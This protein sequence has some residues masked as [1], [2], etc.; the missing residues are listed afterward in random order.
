MV[1]KIFNILKSL[2]TFDKKVEKFNDTIDHQQS[3]IELGQVMEEV[4]PL[5]NDFVMGNKTC[6]IIDDSFGQVTVLQDDVQSI[7]DKY[8]ITDINILCMHSNMAAFEVNDLLNKHK[9]SLNIQYVI[10]D[11]TIGGS[12]R[13]GTENI[14]LNGVDV[15]GFL[16]NF[17]DDLKIVIYT[18]NNLNNYIDS[19]R[20]LIE[21]FKIITDK[22][23]CDFT[24][25]KRS[26]SILER[27]SELAKRLFDIKE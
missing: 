23:I 20:K 6:L 21:K 22:D 7:F 18:G 26:L 10:A 19:N 1:K 2:F 8:G 24:I 13:I 12:K 5:P 14:K 3:I 15:I 4:V 17:C 9:D 27:R 25:I 11:L 16:K